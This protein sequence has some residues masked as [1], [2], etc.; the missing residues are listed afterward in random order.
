MFECEGARLLS[1]PL[2]KLTALQQLNLA[3]TISMSFC[4]A[5][6]CVAV[7]GA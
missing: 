1:E 2:G 7:E 5:M 3:G 4:F 6:G